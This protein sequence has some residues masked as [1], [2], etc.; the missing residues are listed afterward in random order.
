MKRAKYDPGPL[1]S[2]YAAVLCD[3]IAGQ[4]CMRD[5]ERQAA[6]NLA[7]GLQAEVLSRCPTHG[8]LQH[9]GEIFAVPEEEMTRRYE[10]M[11]TRRRWKALTEENGP[12]ILPR[13]F[14]TQY[15]GW[16]CMAIAP[17]PD[18]GIYFAT[19]DEIWKMDNEY[20]ENSWRK[21][22]DIHWGVYYEMGKRGLAGMHVCCCAE[23]HALYLVTTINES[24]LRLDLSSTS[25]S[26]NNVELVHSWWKDQGIVNSVRH[27]TI[28]SKMSRHA[29]G[30]P[31]SCEVV[32]FSQLYGYAEPPPGG[33]ITP[34]GV[35]IEVHP[36]PI[37]PGAK[38][39]RLLIRGGRFHWFH[40][41]MWI[42]VVGDDDDDESFR[43]VHI[44]CLLSRRWSYVHDP[45]D[46]NW[47]GV[48]FSVK[49]FDATGTSPTTPPRQHTDQ[50]MITDDGKL[51]VINTSHGGIA[52]FQLDPVARSGQHIKNVGPISL[53][54]LWMGMAYSVD[55]EQ[56]LIILANGV[57]DSLTLFDTATLEY[58]GS[59][60]CDAKMERTLASMLMASMDNDDDFVGPNFEVNAYVHRKRFLHTRPTRCA[61]MEKSEERGETTLNVLQLSYGNRAHVLFD[62]NRLILY[63]RNHYYMYTLTLGPPDHTKKKK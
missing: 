16:Q 56:R 10:P 25:S 3:E 43:V 58:V 59:F 55:P 49:L 14:T 48:S 6:E 15:F 37:S 30:T 34:H 21:I 8:L 62:R 50:F 1:V 38:V 35:R 40:S 60:H 23:E 53:E 20:D 52:I 9:Y 47:G 22:A 31:S 2:R 17:S 19:T 41:S 18:R 7:P 39:Y 46:G 36:V 27:E 28:A 54:T 24:I 44:P 42:T 13:H 29:T 11:V 63:G 5:E 61:D 4:W 45:S 26:D 32:I 12:K 57:S 51:I 33:V